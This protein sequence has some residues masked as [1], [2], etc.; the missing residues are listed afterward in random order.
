MFNA[1]CQAC[2]LILSYKSTHD[3]DLFVNFGTHTLPTED[4]YDFSSDSYFLALDLNHPYFK[5]NNVSSMEGIYFIGVY[6]Q[7]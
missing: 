6:S 4:S 2:T 5:E 7:V 1:T 3:I